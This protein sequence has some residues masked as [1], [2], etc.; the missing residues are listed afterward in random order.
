MKAKSILAVGSIALDEIETPQDERQEI[1]GGSAMY[2]SVAASLFAPVSLVGIVG[3]DYPEEG[4][5]LFQEH[6]IDVHDV[7]RVPGETFRWGGRYS[8]D[9]STRETLYTHLGVFENF[10]P[11]LSKK[12]RAAEIIYLGNIQPSLQLT[13][14]A[15]FSG[16][17]HI[18][19]DT[20]NLWIEHNREELQVVLQKTHTFLIND[21]EAAQLTGLHDLE[22]AARWLLEAGPSAVVIKKGSA[23]ALLVTA[24]TQRH[25]PIYPHAQQVDP[26]GAGD[27]FAGGLIG[28]IANRGGTDLEAAVINGAAT[29]SYA[30]EGFG[31]EGLLKAT[32]AGVLSRGDAIRNLMD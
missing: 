19:S 20:M 28:H 25:I 1:L 31:L 13:I 26:T 17:H 22:A 6:N 15:N 27:S 16:A 10:Q 29:A 2:F 18:I 11:I 32:P 8:Q 21:E 5:Q 24:D 12:N 14:C 4:W 30:V 9:F 3:S 7:Q 23:G